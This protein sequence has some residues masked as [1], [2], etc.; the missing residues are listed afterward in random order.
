MSNNER[1][2]AIHDSE[3]LNKIAVQLCQAIVTIYHQQP[4]L[5]LEKYRKVKWENQS[6]QLALINKFIEL[7][8]AS[9]NWEEL[10]K[11]VRVSLTAIL[12]NEAANLPNITELVTEIRNQNP[13]N[14]NYANNGFISNDLTLPVLS[15]GIAVLL[16][17]AENLQINTNTEKF[18]ATVCNFPIQV[19]IAFANWGNRGKLD[20]ELHERGY[21]LIHVP[22]GRDNADGKMIAFGASIHE[23]YPH[24]K[25]VF[26]CSSDKVM[27]NLCN[28][29]QQHGL[30]VYQVS[31]HGENINI[32]NNTTAETTI[33]NV[34][35]LPEIPSLEQFILQL[36]TIIR[37]E[38]KLSKSFWIKLSQL[39]QIYKDKYQLNISHIVSKHLPGKRARDIFINYPADFVIHQVD[40]VGELYVTIFEN[41]NIQDTNQNISFIDD[42]STPHPIFNI[43]SQVD[44]EQAI[45]NIFIE[46][47]QTSNNES[48]DISVLASKF[49]QK[50]GRSITEQMKGLK[51]T[52][53]FV[54]FLQSCNY[55]QVQLTDNKWEVSKFNSGFDSGLKSSV[56]SSEISSATDL[57]QALKMII[58][59]LTENNQNSYVDASVLGV[60]F[61]HK[62]GKPITRQLKDIQI[63]SSFIKFL[64]SCNSFQ[65]H[66]NGNKYKVLLS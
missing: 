35:P 63:N 56:I 13:A 54:K 17:D 10:I 5:L 16:L 14:V 64:Q 55:F 41:N 24:A 62:Y 57:E 59:A 15:L 32:F 45:K 53:N 26:V 4:E 30:I 18:L 11:K 65:I 40:D 66:K 47:S 21:D 6:N 42:F 46:L 60:K 33:Y 22:A 23:L 50:Y 3:L 19:K 39:S 29:L 25:A 38:Q 7:L 52:G 31:Q 51:I 48:F 27:T 12:V 43:Q 49:K 9:Q 37:E 1:S 8:S 61:H 28:N 58:L 44:L 2:L 20:V 34:K 36:K